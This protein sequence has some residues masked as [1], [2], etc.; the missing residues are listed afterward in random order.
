LVE[1]SS[2]LIRKL[3]CDTDVIQHTGCMPGTEIGLVILGIAGIKIMDYFT[4]SGLPARYSR[5]CIFQV[6]DVKHNIEKGKW[7]TTIRAGARPAIQA[8]GKL[9]N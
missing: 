4:V 9:A 7:S 2:E 1:P 6:N 5:G 8:I 3:T